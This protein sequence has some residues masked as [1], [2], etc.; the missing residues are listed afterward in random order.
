MSYGQTNLERARV[1]RGKKMKNTHE[2]M[3]PMALELIPM[4]GWTCFRT[5]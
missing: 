4:S 1:Q 3:M 5:L 2:F